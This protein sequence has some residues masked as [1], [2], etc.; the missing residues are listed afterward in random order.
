MAPSRAITGSRLLP[1]QDGDASH[2][3]RLGGELRPAFSL[4]GRPAR[5]AVLA[6]TTSF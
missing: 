3:D 5:I 1:L 2:A 4:A 6:Q